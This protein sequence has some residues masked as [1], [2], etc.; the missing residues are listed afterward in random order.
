MKT[1]VGF[2]DGTIHIWKG[3]SCAQYEE[4]LH[5]IYSLAI[6]YDNSYMNN[7]YI[8]QVLAHQEMNL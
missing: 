6:S 5:S 4:Q 7:Y 8:P 1:A 2:E 3:L